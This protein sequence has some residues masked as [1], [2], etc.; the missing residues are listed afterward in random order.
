MP[1]VE[2]GRYSRIRRAII[3]TGVKIPE[4]HSIGFDP[5]ADRASGLSR[6]RGRCHR[7]R[8]LKG[9]ATGRAILLQQDSLS[10]EQYFDDDRKGNWKRDSG[11]PRE[12][13]CGSGCLSRRRQYGTGGRAIRRIH[14]RA[15][16]RGTEGR[17]QGALPRQGQPQGGQPHQRRNRHRA[18]RQGR[19]PAGRNRRRDDRAR[20]H[21]QQGPPRRQ[22]HPGRLHGG[23]PR[24]RRGAAHPAVPLPGRRRSQHPARAR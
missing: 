23:R 8:R 10:E 14:R 4:L 6:H 11:F 15:R 18:A 17:R 1:G 19:H 2:I 7:G 5:D 3:N 13:D 24:R 21:A 22:R 12:S 16:S 20:R 9:G